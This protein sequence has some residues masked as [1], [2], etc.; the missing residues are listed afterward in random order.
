MQWIFKPL[1]MKQ[2]EVNSRIFPKIQSSLRT[3]KYNQNKKIHTD[4]F[5][6]TNYNDLLFKVHVKCRFIISGDRNLFNTNYLCT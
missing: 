6:N 4:N 2:Q 5:I 3:Y 1:E